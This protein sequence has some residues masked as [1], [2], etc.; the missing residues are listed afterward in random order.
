MML[1]LLVHAAPALAQ[2]A[3][4]ESP[5][6]S[7]FGLGALGADSNAA[8]G[9]GLRLFPGSASAPPPAPPL[10]PA[11]ATA[12]AAVVG[13]AAKPPPAVAPQATA[14]AGKPVPL[15]R[16]GAS[17][18]SAA[19]PTA[20]RSDPAVSQRVRQQVLAAALPSSPNPAGLRQAVE[21]GAPWQ[22]FDRLLVQHGYDPR[23]LADVVAAFYLIAWEVTT[24]GDATTQRA[25]IAAVRGQARQMLAGN[26][27]LARQSEAE[28][29]AT[30]ETLA[31]YA[32]AAAARANDLRVAGNDAALNAF[33]AE[34]AATVARQQGID[35]RRYALTP[36]GFQAR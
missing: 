22:E 13:P 10:P 21:S 12:P 15:A 5:A 32:M 30:A 26:A 25:G 28:R 11:T 7:G 33:R 1:A 8:I 14:T 29:Q 35:L 23:D 9:A 2:K 17:A 27:A 3:A 20:F 16:P 19:S 34:V 24:G 6:V 18:P 4:P 31:F 36:A